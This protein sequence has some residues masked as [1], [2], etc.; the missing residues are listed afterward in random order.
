MSWVEDEVGQVDVLDKNK[1]KQKIFLMLSVENEGEGNME[2][3]LFLELTEKIT[4]MLRKW[5]EWWC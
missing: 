4:Y 1:E 3:N 2:S 5:E